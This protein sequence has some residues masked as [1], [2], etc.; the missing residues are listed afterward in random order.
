[1]ADQLPQEKIF[2]RYQEI[3]LLLLGFILTS[4]VDSRRRYRRMV[5][6][7]LMGARTPGSDL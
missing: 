2:G 3:V 1:M 6:E 7:T 4:I 5:P